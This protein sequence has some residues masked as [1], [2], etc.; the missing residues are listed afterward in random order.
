MVA[1]RGLRAELGGKRILS[2]LD[3]EVGRGEILGIVG[4]SGSGKSVLLRHLIGLMTPTRGSVRLLGQEL[5][6]LGAPARHALRRRLGVL[7][8]EDA[9]PPPRRYALTPPPGRAVEEVP[10]RGWQL[11]VGEPRP[12][13]GLD[14]D[15]IAVREGRLRL[16][17][18]ADA[19]WAAPPGE[20]LQALLVTAFQRS[21]A[22][23]AVARSALAIDPDVRLRT[24]VLRFEAFYEGGAAVPAVEV[25]LAATLLEQPSQ[26]VL[27]ARPFAATRV[28]RSA[29]VRDVVAAVD[30]ATRAALGTLVAWALETLAEAEGG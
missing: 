27:G 26:R 19:R 28:P 6:R 13:V 22:V 11:V 24:R 5:P 29:E 30:E 21:E 1:A 25:E 14:T 23:G 9:L 2:D 17:Y 8:Q 15:R 3:L 7:F 18:Y 12:A 20:M 16:R 4:G 10:A